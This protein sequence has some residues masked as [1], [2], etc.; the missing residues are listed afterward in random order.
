MAA[1]TIARALDTPAWF[2]TP[3]LPSTQRGLIVDLERLELPW[4]WERAEFPAADGTPVVYGVIYAD[5]GYMAGAAPKGCV[6]VH[7]R[8]DVKYAWGLYLAVHRH[9]AAQAD[10]VQL[11]LFAAAA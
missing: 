11:D 4:H 5:V 1:D 9:A 10:L 7:T 6:P 3:Q 8:S 2:T